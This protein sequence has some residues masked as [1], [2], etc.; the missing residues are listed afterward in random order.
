MPD[1]ERVVLAPLQTETS[2]PALATGA[3]LILTATVAVELQVF[4]SLTVTVY[5]V[6]FVGCAVTLERPAWDYRP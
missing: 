2:E 6:E 3:G 4:A 5:V 1:P